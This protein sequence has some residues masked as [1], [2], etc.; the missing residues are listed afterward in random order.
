MCIKTI[1]FVCILLSGVVSA[2][3]NAYRVLHV[4][5]YHSSWIWNQEQ[6]KGFKDG[7]GDLDIEY[8]VVELDTKRHSNLEAILAKAN[9]AKKIVSEWDPDLVYTN[10]DNA[11]KYFAQSYVGT[12]L[13]IVFSAVNRDPSEYDFLGAKNVTGVME[14]EHFIPTLNLLRSIKKEIRKIA[15]IV[16]SDPTWK[17]V[18][19]RMRSNLKQAQGIEVTD[20]LLIKSFADYKQKIRELQNK[21][22]ALAVLGV[23]NLKD[24]MGQDVDYEEVLKWTAQNSKLPDFSF[25]ES[26]VDLGTLCGVSVSGY[27][28]GFLAGK[29]ARQILHDKVSP[30]S[31]NIRSSEK[32]Q[33]ML[34]LERAKALGLKIDVEILLSTKVKKHYIWNQ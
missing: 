11:Q 1:I 9:E 20:W 23:F 10:D 26:R 24:S 3:E 14:Y 2:S 27:E 21:V 7:I 33:P 17:G 32:G 15:V 12:T 30:D 25:W 5:S 8:K 29:M 16:D 31:I 4:M 22:D 18:M 6:S 19:S 13:P 34:N 28:Q